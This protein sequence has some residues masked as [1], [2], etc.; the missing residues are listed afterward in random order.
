M[1]FNTVPFRE[2]E[3]EAPEKAPEPIPEKTPEPELVPA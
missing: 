3:E 1:G 2:G